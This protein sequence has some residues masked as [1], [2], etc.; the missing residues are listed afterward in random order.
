MKIMIG[1]TTINLSEETVRSLILEGVKNNFLREGIIGEFEIK[2]R[3]YHPLSC[4]ITISNPEK[5]ADDVT[6]S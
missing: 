6:E 4:T 5:E 1:E 2:G 3:D